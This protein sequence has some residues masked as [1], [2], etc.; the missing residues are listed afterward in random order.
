MVNHWLK[1]GL[2]GGWPTPLKIDWVKVSWEYE[3]PNWMESHKNSMVP[4]HQP[5][6]DIPKSLPQNVTIPIRIPIVYTHDIICVALVMQLGD[7]NGPELWV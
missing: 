2:V 5:E 4:N 7:F 3:I 1:H 6:H